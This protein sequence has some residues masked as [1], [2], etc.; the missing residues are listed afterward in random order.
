[1]C[2]LCSRID[3]HR[4]NLV[5]DAISNQSEGEK[6]AMLDDLLNSQVAVLNQS[7]QPS[8]PRKS[9]KVPFKKVRVFH[10]NLAW[11]C[12]ALPPF[13]SGTYASFHCKP[14]RVSADAGG[15]L[16][17]EETDLGNPIEPGKPLWQAGEPWASLVSSCTYNF[18]MKLEEWQKKKGGLRR[19]YYG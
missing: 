12:G 3:I 19:T 6:D 9:Q 17:W 18:L 10:L 8:N 4:V 15:R 16:S 2:A 13:G 1:M 5:H 7:M 11:E 14:G